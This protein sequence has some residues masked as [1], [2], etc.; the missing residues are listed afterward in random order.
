MEVL[1]P[2]AHM[3]LSAE[4][5]RETVQA[6]SEGQA[7]GQWRGMDSHDA[8]DIANNISFDP[9]AWENGRD[10]DS[11]EESE[12]R[13]VTDTDKALYRSNFISQLFEL[14]QG[15]Q[16][17]LQLA[18]AHPDVEDAIRNLD[19]ATRPP[20]FEN[21]QPAYSLLDVP[22]VLERRWGPD[23][24]NMFGDELDRLYVSRRTIT[25]TGYPHQL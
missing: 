18:A 4:D 14:L 9:E 1:L 17:V 10:S 7:P 13:P 11:E 2:R 25:F 20:R 3:Y 15:M 8:A 23:A 22:G 19:P 6:V 21:L 16:L 12:S 24:S 5:I